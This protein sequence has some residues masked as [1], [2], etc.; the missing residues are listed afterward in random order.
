VTDIT[1]GTRAALE[2][3]RPWLEGLVGR[4]PPPFRRA[5]RDYAALPGSRTASAMAEGRLRSYA[6]LLDHPAKHW[7]PPKLPVV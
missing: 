6:I 1:E 5:A 2:H 3:D 4:L 7:S